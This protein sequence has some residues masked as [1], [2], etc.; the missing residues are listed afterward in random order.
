EGVGVAAREAFDGPARLGL[1]T[2]DLVDVSEVARAGQRHA[3]RVSDGLSLAQLGVLEARFGVLDRLV[4]ILRLRPTHE[5]SL[6]QIH[7]SLRGRGWAAVTEGA[8]SA[9]K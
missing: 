6:L 4:V 7:L 1:G 8:S 2:A 3:Q 9:T 5:R